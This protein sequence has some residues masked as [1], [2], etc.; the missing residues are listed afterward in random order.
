[1]DTQYYQ[2]VEGVNFGYID[3]HKYTII[4]QQKEM[5]FNDEY[6]KILGRYFKKSENKKVFVYVGDFDEYAD[7]ESVFEN[8]IVPNIGA[9]GK[10]DKIMYYS[11]VQ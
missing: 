2:H 5:D 4:P 7:E 1:M 9:E 10:F 11:P 8:F 3:T 6:E